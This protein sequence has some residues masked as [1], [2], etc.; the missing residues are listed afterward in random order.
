MKKLMIEQE[1]TQKQQITRS[2]SS[3]KSHPK[4]SF[5]GTICRQSLIDQW[6]S[7]L[8]RTLN[9]NEQK[10]VNWTVTEEW[11]S[12]GGENGNDLIEGTRNV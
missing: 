1:S 12:V 4:H 5:C 11:R 7:E 10:C 6:R 2:V 9:E 3:H 8:K